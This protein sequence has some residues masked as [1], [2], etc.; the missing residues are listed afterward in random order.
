[1]KPDE[2]E[3]YVKRIGINN[4]YDNTVLSRLNDQNRDAIVIIMQRTHENDLCGYLIEKMNNG[5]G[6]KYEVLSFPAICEKD[7][8]YQKEGES[9]HEERLPI[10]FLNTFQKSNPV[11]FSCQY[12][13][14]PI[15]KESQE[16]FNEWFK[17]YDNIPVNGRVFTVVDPAFSKK[18]TADYTAIITGKFVGDLL[19]ILEVTHGKFNPAEL[20]DN[21]LYHI[22]KW[23]PEKV[24]VEAFQA[25]QMIGFSLRNRLR[26]DALYVDVVDITQRN[27]KNTKIRRLVPLY[28][29]G[30]IYH[31]KNGDCGIIEQQLLKFPRGTHDDSI[32]SLSHGKS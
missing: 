7:N 13:Q 15:A 12:Q 3:S 2:A 21:I 19:Y 1:L 11:V 9:I 20:E 24:G 32:D 14:N 28:R 4:W 29:N 31:N 30:Q 8:E 6:D 27:D 22:K 16:F 17:Y 23:Q 26:K 25:Q 10:S 18:T 5:L